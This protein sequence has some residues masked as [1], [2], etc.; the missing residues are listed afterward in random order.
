[1]LPA[2]EAVDGWNERRLEV[3]MDVAGVGGGG[4]LLNGVFL[5]RLRPTLDDIAFNL[6]CSNVSTDLTGVEL[7]GSLRLLLINGVF[8][9]NG[10]AQ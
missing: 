6:G 7:G 5:K 10:S 8:G 2:E 1:M 3:T 9:V 4:A